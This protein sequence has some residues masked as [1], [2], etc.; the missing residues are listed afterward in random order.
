MTWNSF[1]FVGVS[2][3]DDQHKR[4]FD[5]LDE[6][7]AQESEGQSKSPSAQPLKELLDYTQEHFSTEEAMMRKARYPAVA[8]HREL[9]QDLTDQVRDFLS[10][11]QVGDKSVH[12]QLRSFLRQWL[13]E[14]I[15][16]EDRAFGVW[17]NA[18]NVK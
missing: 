3:L 6:L 13:S 4:L 16:R 12:G 1:Y 17:L 10:R 7:D 5:I 18:H 14:H 9:H 11:D 15:Q 2:V 8:R